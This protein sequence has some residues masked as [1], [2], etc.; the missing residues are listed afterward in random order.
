M[1]DEL[2]GECNADTKTDLAAPTGR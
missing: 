1:C 2:S